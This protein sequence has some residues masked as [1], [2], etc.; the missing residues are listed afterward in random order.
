[1]E[2]DA[3][4]TQGNELNQRQSHDNDDITVPDRTFL[5]MIGAKA[6]CLDFDG[7]FQD[8]P[9]GVRNTDYNSVFP[10]GVNIASTTLVLKRG[11]ALGEEFRGNGVNVA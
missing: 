5:P 11:E 2:E 10:A 8:A 7:C 1:M 3:T 9:V 4:E 6:T